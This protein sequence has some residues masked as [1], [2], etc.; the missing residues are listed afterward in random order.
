MF[1]NVPKRIITKTFQVQIFSMLYKYYI[2]IKYIKTVKIYFTVNTAS[3]PMPI[4]NSKNNVTPVMYLSMLKLLC[5]CKLDTWAFS[6]LK[7][8]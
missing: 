2:Y 3:L 6:L 4:F 1:L 7:Q 8:L 5:C